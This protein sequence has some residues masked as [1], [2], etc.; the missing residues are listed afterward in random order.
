MDEMVETQLWA[1]SFLRKVGFEVEQTTS[2]NLPYRVEGQPMS[3][4][5]LCDVAR[6]L[7]FG[8]PTPRSRPARHHLQ[9]ILDQE[10]R[11]DSKRA[12]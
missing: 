1:L 4:R 6:S 10:S 11:E 12:D 8:A 7:A 3:E 9:Q 5:G 2:A